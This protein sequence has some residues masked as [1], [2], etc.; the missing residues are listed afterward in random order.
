M[1]KRISICNRTTE[2][3][4][5]EEAVCFIKD[6]EARWVTKTPNTAPLISLAY[7]ALE[8]IPEVDPAIIIQEENT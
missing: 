3:R 7:K 6:G 5:F 4:L 8:I 1:E 2:G